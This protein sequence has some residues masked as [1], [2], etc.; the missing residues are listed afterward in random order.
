MKKFILFFL[1]LIPVTG[2]AQSYVFAP[3]IKFN[4]RPGLGSVKVSVVFQ[5]NRTYT[6]KLNERCTKD[7]LFQIFAGYIQKS[8]PGVSLNVLEEERYNDEPQQGVVT[9]KINLLKYESVLMNTVYIAP[10]KYKV[11]LTD[12][13]GEPKEFS[14]TIT[15]E[16]R[17]MNTLGH[18]SGQIAANT[19]FRKALEKLILMFDK[20]Q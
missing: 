16:A 4:E 10:T 7:E 14:E 5:D 12:N 11:V 1:L 2:I 3:E 19:S 13:R 9:L 18:K 6:R 15:I 17:Q 20:L 8:L